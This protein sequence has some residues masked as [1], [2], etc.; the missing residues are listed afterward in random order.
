MEQNHQYI[1]ID[2]EFTMPEGKM[3][4]DGFYPEII[5]VGAVVVKND[6]IISEY[7][8]FVKP[9]RFPV[10]SKRC[11]NF[12]GIEQSKVDKGVAFE[13]LIEKLTSFEKN[14]KSTIVTW[15]N[16]DMKVLRQ[17]CQANGMKFPFKGALVDLSM[18]YKRFFGDQNQTGLWK[19]V[20]EYGTDGVGKHHRAL[21]DALTTYN[22][23]KLVD[24]DKKY[25]EKHE[26]TT[27]GDLIDLSEVFNK[28]A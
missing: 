5:E 4:M 9:K 16:M 21:D 3:K 20:K 14:G 7:S 19:A 22:I 28:F 26:P 11:K 13:V 1:F 2:F 23:Y 18:E 10:L 15:G 8:E 27:I 24:K 12:L 6:E 25:M 17:N